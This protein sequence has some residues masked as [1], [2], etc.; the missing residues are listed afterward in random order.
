M[1][2]KA[3]SI[4]TGITESLIKLLVEYF[5]AQNDHLREHYGLEDVV[6]WILYEVPARGSKCCTY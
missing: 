2:A 3:H 5:V 1:E 6:F 4:D